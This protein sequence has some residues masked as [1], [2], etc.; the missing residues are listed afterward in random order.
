MRIEDPMGANGRRRVQLYRAFG[1]R[2]SRFAAAWAL[3]AAP[4][5]VACQAPAQQAARPDT[6]VARL[7][8]YASVETLNADLLA[9][10]SATGTLETWCA[11]HAMATPAVLKAEHLGGGKT[12]DADV[13]RQLQ[14]GPD[15]TVGYRHV[16]LACGGHVLS[17]ADNWYVPARL[18]P[19]MNRALETTD[20]PFGKV[21]APLMP[22]RQ[23]LAMRM[24]WTAF[25]PGWELQ[26]PPRDHSDQPLALPP[27]LF[28]HE[29]VVLDAQHRPLALVV[30]HYTR[31]VLAFADHP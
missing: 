4:A 24:D 15:E 31:D 9:S 8:A 14:V 11:T 18:T 21:I 2:A 22:T 10:R 26:A 12:A 19:A 20:T 30:E 29:A 6:A 17:D 27:V 13:R 16:R 1:R 23:T 25:P 7:R 3:A 5:I 28:E